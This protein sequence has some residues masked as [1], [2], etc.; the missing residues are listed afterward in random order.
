MT[1]IDVRK[2]PYEVVVEG[3]LLY[4]KEKR[5]KSASF[6]NVERERIAVLEIN[7]RLDDSDRFGTLQPALD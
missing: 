6:A 7:L 3:W 4:I 1:S 2:W 5:K